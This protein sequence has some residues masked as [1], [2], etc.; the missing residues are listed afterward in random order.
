MRMEKAMRYR[1]F[2]IVSTTEY[3][4]VR[5][6]QLTG[7]K[8]I[9]KGY[10]CQIYDTEDVERNQMFDEFDL[11]VGHEI[12]DD[13]PSPEFAGIA[14][15]VDRNYDSLIDVKWDMQG[16]RISELLGRTLCWI[17]ENESGGE[18]YN[19]F[20]EVLGL[21]DEEIRYMGYTSLVPYFDREQYAETIANYLIDEGTADTVSGNIHI[22]FDEIN[23]R[24][25]VCLPSDRELLESI[26]KNLLG[27]SEI[28]ADLD[29]TEDF[30][31]MFYTVFCPN[32]EDRFCKETEETPTLTM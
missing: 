28:I 9:C 6:N 19:T 14:K 10:Y 21:T 13:T 23:E 31:L 32:C 12:S 8:E 1:G 15:Y 24:F 30:D 4:L 2:E 27:Q 17:G 25:A 3:D 26:T 16:N 7:E 18:L 5:R 29:T 22:P 11:A 20:S